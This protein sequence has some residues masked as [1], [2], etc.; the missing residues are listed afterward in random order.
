[1]VSGELEGHDLAR[2]LE[3]FGLRDGVAVLVLAPPRQVR[4]AV[5]DALARAVSEQTP[6]GLVAGS[7]RFSCV[8]LAP[9]RGDDEALFALAEQ[10]RARVSAD[11]GVA[12]DAGAGRAVAP[13]D[14]RRAFHEARCALEA[15]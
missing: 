8:L 6:A 2:R 10:L 1:M 9:G 7:G 3:P 4:A 5:E 12:L 13:G 11:V 14:A 15:R